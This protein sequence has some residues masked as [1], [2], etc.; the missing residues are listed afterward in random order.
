MAWTRD[1]WQDKSC[2]RFE[3][4]FVLIAK[5]H[6]DSSWGF[7]KKTPSVREGVLY[8]G[9]RKIQYVARTNSLTFQPS[10]IFCSP[11]W[12]RAGSFDRLVTRIWCVSSFRTLSKTYGNREQLR[13]I[14]H[15]FTNPDLCVYIPTVCSLVS[16]SFMIGIISFFLFCFWITWHLKNN[17]NSTS[18]SGTCFRVRITMSEVLRRASGEE[19][20]PWGNLIGGIKKRSWAMPRKCSFCWSVTLQLR[21]STTTS[22]VLCF[23]GGGRHVCCRRLTCPTALFVVLYPCSVFCDASMARPTSCR[24]LMWLL[25]VGTTVMSRVTLRFSSLEEAACFTSYV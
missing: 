14:S 21:L 5:S 18:P 24:Y 23:L 8:F 11:N 2:S 9:E 25:C 22:I 17:A 6:L 12:S 7:V 16:R 19:L 10:P 1:I 15:L 4:R 13:W 3:D 20:R